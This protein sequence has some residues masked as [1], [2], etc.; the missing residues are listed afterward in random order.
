ML[1]TRTG[2]KLFRYLNYDD[3]CQRWKGNNAYIWFHVSLRVCSTILKFITELKIKMKT[4]CHANKC[5]PL[6]GVFLRWVWHKWNKHNAAKSTTLTMK[7]KHPYYCGGL[8]LN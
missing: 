5:R 4:Q 8:V 2:W 6:L 7:N 1:T 3:G